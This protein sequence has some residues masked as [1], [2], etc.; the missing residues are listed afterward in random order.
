M[1]EWRT[2]RNNRTC[3]LMSFKLNLQRPQEPLA[4]RGI[5]ATVI[6]RRRPYRRAFNTRKIRSNRG[7]CVQE[8]LSRPVRFKLTK[9]KPSNAL[10]RSGK[11]LQSAKADG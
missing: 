1:S 2:R 10:G 6:T 3:E 4:D 9:H 7:S 5:T 11:D 8:A